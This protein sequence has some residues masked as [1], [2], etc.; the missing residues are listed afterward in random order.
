MANVLIVED[1]PIAVWS[2]RETLE[3]LGH[4][5]VDEVSSGQQAVAAA[6]SRRPDLVLMDICLAGDLDGIEAAAVIQGQF[7]IPVVYLT[8]YADEAMVQRAIATS[9]FGYVVKPFRSYELQTTIAIALHRHQQEKYLESVESQLV[10]TLESLGDGTIT[11]DAEERVNF[12]NPVAEALTGWSRQEAQGQPIGTVLTLLESQNQ[13]LSCS[14]LQRALQDEPNSPSQDCLLKTRQGITRFINLSA[15][16]I[17]DQ[18]DHLLGG[19]LVFRD[20]T[21][22]KQVEQRLRQQ[23]VR[24][25]ILNDV[26][27]AI[28]HSLDLGAIL[29]A[30]TQEVQ[31]LLRV[32]RVVIYRFELDGSGTVMAEALAGNY[33]AMQ[34]VVLSDPCLAMAS[35]LEKYLSG[36]V[37]VLPDVQTADL[38]DCYVQ[39]LNQFEVRANLVVPILCGEQQLWGLLAVQHCASPRLWEP[40]EVDLM[41]QLTVQVGIAIQQSQL[42]QQ[43]QRQAQQEALLNEVVQ[44]I[45][46]SL[47]LEQV[48]HQATDALLS[49]FQA[50]RSVVRLGRDTDETFFY[51]V[52]NSAPGVEQLLDGTMPILSNP[53]VQTV[54][55]HQEA[56]AIDDVDTEPWLQPLIPFFRRTQIRAVLAIAI[57]CEGRV[58]GLLCLHQCD[59]IRHW[60][61]DEKHLLA[62]VVDQLAITLQQVELY[63]KLHQANQELK[64]L[65]HLDGLTQLANRRFFDEYLETEYRRH[66]QSD[67]GLALILCDVDHFKQFNDTYGHQVGDDCLK[68]I[69]Q[70]LLQVLKGSTALA[71]RFGGEE[72]ALVLPGTHQAEAITLAQNIQV[73]LQH[74]QIGASVVIPSAKVTLSM[75]IASLDTVAAVSPSALIDL[76]DKALYQAKAQGRNR[77]CCAQRASQTTESDY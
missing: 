12:M 72:F 63:R 50:S 19:V 61:D 3:K 34:G 62:K 73:A 21:E 29:A 48:L 56:V 58:K 68:A 13:A 27:L 30:T 53:L 23:A 39:L 69:A 70:T 66:K 7:S 33:P 55:A 1:E 57:R 71:A 46:S 59:R 8:A 38:A 44:A 16:A 77:Y 4:V 65:A 25:R 54:F 35:C 22:Y 52:S 28:R 10:T 36:H 41:R 2:I 40:W 11:T 43:S 9:P 17:R 64:R 5:V 32:N 15:S 76:A 18:S 14:P 6:R 42:Y 31:R 26:A 51:S 45:R 24:E 49:A 60:H 47:N 75:G 37:Q 74:I 20:I 67:T